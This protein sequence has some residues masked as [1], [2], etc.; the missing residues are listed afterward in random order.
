VVVIAGKGHETEQVLPDGAGGTIRTH[1][2]DREVARTILE[3]RRPKAPG[4]V[5]EVKPR[6]SLGGRA[7]G[8]GGGRP[9]RSHK[10][11]R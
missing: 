9:K 7:P 5:A 2:D 6:R 4:P 1:F 3:E 8:P 10:H 11:G